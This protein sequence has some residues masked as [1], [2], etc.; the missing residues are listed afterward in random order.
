MERPLR[1]SEPESFPCLVEA[2]AYATIYDID[3]R[4]QFV[5][6]VYILVNSAVV[7]VLPEQCKFVHKVFLGNMCACLWELKPVQIYYA[8]RH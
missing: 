3:G 6:T 1:R 5:H 2:G 7:N 8:G 4:L